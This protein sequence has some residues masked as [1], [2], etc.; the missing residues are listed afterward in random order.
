MEKIAISCFTH[1]GKAVPIIDLSAL[2][3]LAGPENVLSDN[4]DQQVADG[5]SGF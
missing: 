3:K 1:D 2:F 5:V 4:S